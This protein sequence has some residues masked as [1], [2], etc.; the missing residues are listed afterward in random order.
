MES[1]KGKRTYEDKEIERMK[2]TFDWCLEKIEDKEVE[3]GV[4]Y[5]KN[6]LERGSEFRP[7]ELLSE[8]AEELRETV[9]QFANGELSKDEL[10]D[11]IGEFVFGLS[12]TIVSQRKK[13]ERFDRLVGTLREMQEAGDE[14]PDFILLEKLTAVLNENN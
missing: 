11:C 13:K 10:I 5:L 2:S 12:S 7:N 1:N 14:M 6:L 9:D 4:F 8:K 3:F